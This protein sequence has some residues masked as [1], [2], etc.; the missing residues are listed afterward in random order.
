MYG[1]LASHYK[2]AGNRPQG[3]AQVR[4]FTPS[5]SE[6]GWSAGGHS[7]VEVVTDD[8]PFLVDSLT[9]ELVAPAARRARGH[10][11]A[12][13]RRP[14]HHR[15]AAERAAGRGRLA[16]AAR[17]G[18]SASPGCTSRSTGC[19]E[20]RGPHR[21]RGR[22]C[23]G[24]CA[25]SARRSR[26]GRRCTPRCS[27]IVDE[28]ENDPPPLDPE[29]VRQGRELLQWLADDHF[30][31][32]GYREYRLER[33]GDDE[34]LRAIPGTGFGILRADQDMSAS[35]GKL[36]AL[37]K[38]KAREK[39]LLVLAKANS[40]ATVH[41]PAYLDYVG[42][43]KFDERRGGR[44]AP[45]PRPVLQRRLHRVAD[46]DPAAAG[47]GGRGA[48]AQRLRPPQPRRQGADGHARDLP[49]RRAV[50]HPGRRAGADRRGRDARPR[51][52]PGADVRPPRHLRPLR[53]RASSTC[54]ATATTPPSASGSPRSSRS[55]S[56]A[57][58]WSSPSASTSPPPPGCTSWCTRPR[59]STSSTSTPSTSSAASPTPRARG[60]TTSRAP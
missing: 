50:P 25:T 8:M 15:R 56:A 38:A 59:A 52:P 30:T 58:R 21:D 43:K 3:T 35:F 44:R 18:R 55:A 33:D 51:A 46:P 40:R 5:L 27:R 37:V 48:Q 10:P 28:L 31:F 7:V 32:L 17:A 4:V 2:L 6:H 12:L 39:T 9:M 53:L 54:P 42:V 11:P 13:R 16:R 45:L 23:S 1:A 34:L 29:E 20:G 26:T 22:P 49:A 19:R 36:P 14:R 60:A 57:S 24:C 41:R 47:E